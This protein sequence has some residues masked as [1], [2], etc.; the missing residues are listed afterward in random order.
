M[1]PNELTLPRPLSEPLHKLMFNGK[2]T[3]A[4]P[5]LQESRKRAQDQLASLRADHIRSVN[6]TPY[7]VSVTSDLYTIMHDLWLSEVPIKELN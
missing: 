4:I 7:K 2:L 1:P 3:G 5:S 6:P